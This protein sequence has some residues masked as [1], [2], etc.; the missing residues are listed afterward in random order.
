M[1]ASFFFYD[2]E[3]TGFSARSG[4]IMQFAGQRTDMN[5]KPIGTPL[6]YF[7]K[8]TPDVL[9]SPDAVLVTGITP[10]QTLKDGLTEAE[11][12]KI[13]YDEAVQPDTIFVGFNTVRFDD[14]FMRFLHYRNFYDAYEWQWK[15]G[16]SRWDLLD[17]V[18]MMRALRPDGIKWPFAPDGKP[19]NRLELLAKVNKLDHGKAHN[20][21]SDVQATIDIARLVRK[22]QP[23]LFNYLLDI[24]DK[25]KAK[26][27]ITKGEPFVYTTGRYSSEYL[28]T[29]AA[30]FFT[31]HPQPG[32]ALVY[33]LRHDPTPFI[34]MTVEQLLEIWQFTKDPEAPPR[35]PVK[36]VKFNR[37]PAVAPLGVMKDAQSQER[38]SLT[39]ETITTNRTLLQ[40]HQRPFAEKVLQAVARLDAK[41]QAEQTT[42]IDNQSTVDT[43]LYE[44][45]INDADKAMLPKVR[46]AQ[47]EQLNELG[48]QFRDERLKS[49][50]PL[51]KARNYPSSLDSSER[52]AWDAFCR[53]QLFDGG[54]T[55]RLANYFARLSELAASK[56]SGEQQYILE[57]LQL[58]GQSIVP[59]DA[60]ENGVG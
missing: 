25:K 23:D 8:L 12:L 3:T 24:R 32:Q 27:L 19:T 48:A 58:Y 14:E 44:K 49:L 33:D 21:L 22:K 47:P 43:R 16:C 39:L 54:E 57:E 35:L 53:Q 31:D 15:D 30:I 52:A 56:L 40:K 26:A 4:R 2:L 9:P 41:R 1:A 5:L 42:L 38:I 11:F 10:Q 55:S 36:T 17:M 51:Y 34:D 50:L 45:F 6:N 59:S 46:G 28:H 20:A 29:S 13:F 18:R 37:C 7:I 60:D